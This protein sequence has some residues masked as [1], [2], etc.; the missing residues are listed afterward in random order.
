MG[1][2]SYRIDA[3][4]RSRRF[5]HPS[6]MHQRLRVIT[7]VLRDH[8]LV[9]IEAA[10]LFF[11]MAEYATWI[12]LLVFA[13]ARGGAAA[14]GL[15]SVIQLLP[16]AVVAPLAAYAG[17]R[18]R[19]DR[20]LFVGYVVQAVTAAGVA[21]GLLLDAPVWL[22]YVLAAAAASSYTFTR[23]A[24]GALLPSITRTPEDLTAANVTSGVVEGAGIMLGPVVAGLIL[25]GSEPGVVFAVFAVLLAT[26]AALVMR[27]PIDPAAVEAPD[28]VDASDVW[29]A[30][31]GGFRALAHEGD[32]RTIVLLLSAGTLVVGALD[33]LFVATAIDLL[34]LGEGAA[35]YLNAAFGAGGIVGA[36]ITVVLV[37]RRRLTPPLAGGAAVFGAPVAAIAVLPTPVAALALFAVGGAGRS[38]ADVAG[39]TLLQR[40]APD[41]VL[42]RVFGVL[43][44]LAMV[45]LALGSVAASVAVST[46]GVRAA[47]ALAGAFVPL[48]V[49]VLAR[50][51]LAIDR[52]AE[53]PDPE[54]L[55][56]LR[57]LDLFAP[58]AA[59][60]FERLVRNV[61]RVVADA[62]TTV[63]REGD[64]GDRFYVIASGEAAVSRN[65]S[66]VATLGAG[67][68]FG[69]IA[70]L[71]DEPR[72]ATVTAVTAMELLAL[73]RDPFL[74]AVTGHPQSHHAADE[75]AS[76]RLA[77]THSRSS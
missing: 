69:E 58:L 41:E 37:G 51:L 72:V 57:S 70:L 71:R 47:L 48:A 38:V 66:A 76:K 45:A 54:V 60:A 39:R 40:V 53:A 11:N 13:Y 63:I 6:R 12:A 64:T 32:A 18:F 65:G 42:A 44:G 2:K 15:V 1:S 21:A 23:P 25:T 68:G 33:V 34:A 4:T 7:S 43:E 5:G 73:E 52:H 46:L 77:E 56:L 74:E 16:S 49:A 29:H 27:L 67:D 50:R 9:R 35:G 26:G 14:A 61:E 36:A 62:G 30:T 59:S 55:G 17:D 19:R 3:A 24:Q 28:R 75:L 20:V 22:V 31:L 8:A 10:F